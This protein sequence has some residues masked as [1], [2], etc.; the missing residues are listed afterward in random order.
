MQNRRWSSSMAKAR[1]WRNKTNCICQPLHKRSREKVF[2]GKRELLAV[3]WGLERFRFHQYGNKV[4]LFADHQEL[5]PLLKRNK[6]NKQCS[7]GLTRWL[8]RPNHFDIILNQTPGKEIKFTDFIGRNSTK[9]L[10][11]EENYEEVFVSNVIAQLA[12]VNGV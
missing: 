9:N 11:S 10:E 1:K 5:E 4:H 7:A 3:V 2:I 6:I 8:Y 12:T